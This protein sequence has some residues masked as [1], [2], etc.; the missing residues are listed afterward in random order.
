M[1]FSRNPSL[2]LAVT[3]SLA[4]VAS[5]AAQTYYWRGGAGAWTT[6][7][8]WAGSA[9]GSMAGAVPAGADAVFSIDGAAGDQTVTFGADGAVASLRFRSAGVTSIFGPSAAT[10]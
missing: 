10:S 1:K 5:V 9:D 8:N 2:I 7:G 3:A 4:G 6:A